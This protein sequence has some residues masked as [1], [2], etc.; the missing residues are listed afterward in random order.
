MSL[1]LFTVLILNIILKFVHITPKIEFLKKLVFD[2]KKFCFKIFFIFSDDRTCQ[3]GHRKLF[4]SLVFLNYAI[5]IDSGNFHSHDFRCHNHYHFQIYCR[6]LVS[7]RGLQSHTDYNKHSML[8]LLHIQMIY[9]CI[10]KQ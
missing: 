6:L 2:R 10:K 8:F 3:A 7:I 1:R 4:S 9:D 5:T